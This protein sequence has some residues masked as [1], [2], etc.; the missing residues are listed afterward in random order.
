[1]IV[2]ILSINLLG[3]GHM[4]KKDT[5]DKKSVSSM[6]FKDMGVTEEKVRLFFESKKPNAIFFRYGFFAVFFMLITGVLMNLVFIFRK[7][8]II[9]EKILEKKPVL[10]GIMDVVKVVI[11]VMFLG[12]VLI[13]ASSIISKPLHFNM[14]INLFMIL[15]TFLIDII[16]G[17]VILC[18]VLVKYRGKL[19]NLGIA[20]AGFYKNILSGIT[21]YM[22]ILPILIA[23]LILSMLFLSAIGYKS[24][25]QPVF[26]MLFE[27]KRSN[28]VLFLTIFVSILGPIIEEIFFR[29]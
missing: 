13:T 12:Y 5:P 7:E 17:I 23:V 16:A 14:D 15:I 6:T 3:I 1:M 9:P 2:F 27:E 20:R 24:P 21:A 4:R 26:D 19:S 8:K 22:F 10:W 28:V 29:G 11:I 25:P 18:F